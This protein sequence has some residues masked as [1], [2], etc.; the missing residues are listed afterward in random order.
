MF[1]KAE[2]L[3]RGGICVQTV[4]RD[5]LYYCFN[6]NKLLKKSCVGFVFL[7]GGT[8]DFVNPLV[9]TYTLQA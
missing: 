7:Y 2:N 3:P 4:D 9:Q 1:T 8:L 5:V 6:S